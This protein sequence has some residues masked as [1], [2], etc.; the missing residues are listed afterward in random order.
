MLLWHPLPSKIERRIKVF[1]TEFFCSWEKIGGTIFAEVIEVPILHFSSYVVVLER[2]RGSGSTGA[3]LESGLND[4]AVIGIVLAVGFVF[5]LV[6][7]FFIVGSGI[8]CSFFCLIEETFQVVLGV[9]G[10]VYMV[11]LVLVQRRSPPL[12]P[13]PPPRF[14]HCTFS[15]PSFRVSLRPAPTL[16]IVQPPK[17]VAQLYSPS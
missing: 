9:L 3:V 16:D 12:I 7:K 13:I 4:A 5:D 10:V 15:L 6:K 11:T 8:F 2:L 1:L 17:A 14:C